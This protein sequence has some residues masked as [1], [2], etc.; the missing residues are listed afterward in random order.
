MS[1]VEIRNEFIRKSGRYDLGSV[2]GAD[3]GANWYINA[4]QRMLDRRMAN[5]DLYAKRLG[6]LAVGEYL[7]IFRFAKSITNIWLIDQSDG[8]TLELERKDYAWIRNEYGERLSA[9]DNGTPIYWAPAFVRLDPNLKISEVDFTLDQMDEYVI[10]A[11]QSSNGIIFAPP[12][13]TA[14]YID[15]LGK[16]YSEKLVNNGDVSIWTE[17]YPNILLFAAMYELEVTL[18][19]TAGQE[20]W[21]AAIDNELIGIDMDRVDFDTNHISQMGG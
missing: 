13:D 9:M 8:S 6:T 11:S 2:D 4:G 15:V 18:R 5:D 14:Y 19:N 17:L 1:L 7:K 16:F 10:D 21:L 3:N 20:D 12:T